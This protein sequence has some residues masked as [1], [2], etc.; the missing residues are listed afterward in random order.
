MS[1]TRHPDAAAGG[2]VLHYTDADGYKAIVSQQAWLFRAAQPP[3]NRPFGAYF[4][5]LLPDD[6]KLA[7]GTRLPT[8]KRTHVFAFDGSQGL[9]PVPGGKGRYNLWTDQ[10]YEV[11]PDRQRYSGPAEGLP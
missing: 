4:T 8:R 5:T 6:N 2:W 11:T 9:Q 10:N 3:G 7:A 1:E